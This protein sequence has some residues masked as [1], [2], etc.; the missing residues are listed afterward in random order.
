MEQIHAT[1]TYYLHNPANIAAYLSRLAT[2]REQRY[3]ESMSFFTTFSK[4]KRS[5][6]AVRANA[7]K[8]LSIAN[9]VRTYA[10]TL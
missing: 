10:R 2:W 5:P 1:I 7:S 9:K 8:L 3:Q 6:L 4:E